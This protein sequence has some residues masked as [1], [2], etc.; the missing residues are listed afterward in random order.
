LYS[1]NVQVLFTKEGMGV[2]M[3]SRLEGE[4]LF[5]MGNPPYHLSTW[6]V[7]LTLGAFFGL[8]MLLVILW[9]KFNKKRILGLTAQPPKPSPSGEDPIPFV[10]D[11]I[12]DGL[13][14]S[15]EDGEIVAIN[16][17]LCK[18]A[19]FSAPQEIQHKKIGEL[20]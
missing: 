16:P 19:C 3:E 9:G 12:E 1:S 8:G 15:T 17:N 10:W 14:L 2:K 18:M 7:V 20:F 11:S 5:M 6:K 13:L 4:S